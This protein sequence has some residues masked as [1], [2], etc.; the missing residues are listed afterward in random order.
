MYLV[1]MCFLSRR[2][3]PHGPR[4]RSEPAI[5]GGHPG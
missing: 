4:A 2:S 1:L 3:A 5:V